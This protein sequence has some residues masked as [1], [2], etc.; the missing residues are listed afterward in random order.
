[1]K[2]LFRLVGGVAAVCAFALSAGR[3]AGESVQIPA[4]VAD[5]SGVTIAGVPEYYWYYGCSPTSG[6]M[7]QAWW[8]QQDG[9]FEPL[10]DGT[11]PHTLTEVHD[12]IASAGHIAAGAA[13]GL[14]YGS[15]DRNGNNVED[16]SD[17]ALWDCVADFMRTEDGGTAGDMIP[18]GMVEYAAYCGLTAT[19]S[20]E[21]TPLSPFG[22]GDFGWVDFMAEID[23]GRPMLLSVI[24]YDP[25]A[26]EWS[27][28][29]VLAY[30]YLDEPPDPQLWDNTEAE[31]SPTGGL[32]S[33][34][35]FAVMD[36]WMNGGGSLGDPPGAY[37]DGAGVEW[38]PYYAFDQWSYTE[39]FDWEVYAAVSYAVEAAGPGPI[40]EP[41]SLVLLAA[42]ALVLRRAR[43]RRAA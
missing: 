7:L 30:G 29:T 31:G 12:L 34:G 25:L 15:W 40:P 5:R 16:A 11:A 39:I 2:R 20:R 23:A 9:A 27:A 33:P 17:V 35:W 19:A 32:D 28:H 26:A 36:T 43:R 1:M 8:E 13:K 22:V 18:V 3:A 41:A 4:D 10:V 14:T 42:G 21:Q 38:W 6:G 24:T 37:L